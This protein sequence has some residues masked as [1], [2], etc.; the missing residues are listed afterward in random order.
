[1]DSISSD[2]N[3]KTDTRPNMWRS[4]N[5]IGGER[6]VVLRFKILPILLA[7]ILPAACFSPQTHPVD[8]APIP[9]NARILD[10]PCSPKGVMLCGAV[11]VL[12]GDTAVE[13]RSACIVYVEPSG[14]RVEQCGSL[15]S[16]RP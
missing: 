1:V 5:P 9:A 3:S 14:R 10:E 2:L 4:S 13:R 6:V 11:S 15:P 12:S 8:T 16:S 7:L